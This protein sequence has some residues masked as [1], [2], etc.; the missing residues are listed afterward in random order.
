MA[1]ALKALKIIS[2]ILGVG[3]L[4]LLVFLNLE[5]F[6]ASSI[7]LCEIGKIDSLRNYFEVFNESSSTIYD[8]SINEIGQWIEDVIIEFE[9]ISSKTPSEYLESFLEGFFDFTLNFM[10]YFCNIGINVLLLCYI[11]MH[12]TFTGTQETIKT[13]P[14]AHLYIIVDKTLDTAKKTVLNVIKK[15]LHFLSINRR[16]ITIQVLLILVA[17]GFLYRF[18]V[19][20]LIFIITYI[21]HMINFETYVV[22][23]EIFEYLFILVFPYLKYIPMWI[24][25]PVLIIVL[26]LTAVARANFKLQKNHERLKDFAENSLTQTTF[27]NGPPGTGKTLLNVSLSL[28]SEENYIEELERKLLDYELKYKYINFASVRNNP[29]AYPEHKEYFEIYDKLTNRK[30]Y[31][32]SNYTIH[33]PYFDDNSKSWDFEYMKKNINYPDK[34]HP[35]EEYIVISLSEFDKEYN[36]HDDKKAVGEDGVATFFSTVSHDLKRHCK[37]FVDYQLKDQVPLRIRGNS[38][39][40]ITVKDRKKKYPF[41]LLLYYLPIKL[42]LKIN[43][44][45]I[46]KY[47]TKKK[48]VERKSQRR[49]IAKYKRNDLTVIYLMLRSITNTLTKIAAWFDHYYYF[50]LKT[51][52]SQEDTTNGKDKAININLCDLQ[53]NNNPLYDS[54]FLSFAYEQM[55]KGEFRDL[56]KNKSLRP[57]QDELRL[58]HSRFYDKLLGELE[59]D[60]ENNNNNI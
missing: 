6:K 10:M 4:L 30:S 22:V 46:K 3:I 11:F 42:L 17:N 7:R 28:A 54:T 9:E 59:N 33:S 58:C 51:V 1:K 50:R 25:I 34:L 43:R 48:R 15:G 56:Y 27:I 32:I 16:K 35:L 23:F 38:E 8:E 39:Y 37:I 44:G 41:L 21:I 2:I 57:T 40:F 29:S 47:A 49:G 26:F 13:S 14:L 20:A 19:E 5:S 45:L 24:W 55:K 60:E 12:E 53:Y 36:S 52:V 18:L 31:L